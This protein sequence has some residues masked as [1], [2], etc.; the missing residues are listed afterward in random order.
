M[1]W[2][3]VLLFYQIGSA[4]STMGGDMDYCQ[5]GQGTTVAFVD[6]FKNWANSVETTVQS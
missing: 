1:V 4:V 5:K 2:V 3:V 6:F